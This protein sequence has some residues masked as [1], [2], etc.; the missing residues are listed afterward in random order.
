[1]P[2]VRSPRR[3]RNASSGLTQKPSSATIDRT[4]SYSA[5]VVVIVPS[6]T[7]ACPPMY[8]VAA[9][10]ETST[11]SAKAGRKYGVAQ[12][13]SI[14]TVTPAARAAA[15]IAGTSCTSNVS[16]PG[17]SRKTTFV[18]GRKSDATPPPTPGS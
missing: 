1:M 18:S 10:I 7:S 17:D 16:D 4:G 14:T 13:L 11:P 6:I 9:M 3:A 5:S 8:L 15:A 12:L 2:N